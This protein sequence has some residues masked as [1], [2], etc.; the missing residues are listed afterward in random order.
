M[1]EKNSSVGEDEEENEEVDQDG[2]GD[3][4]EGDGEEELGGEEE[5]L[6]LLPSDQ[7]SIA[8]GSRAQLEAKKMQCDRIKEN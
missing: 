7:F 8:G 2:E 6:S 5:E 3:E 1:A 4:E